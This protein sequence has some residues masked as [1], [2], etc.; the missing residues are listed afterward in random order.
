MFDLFEAVRRRDP[1]ARSTLEILLTYPGVH[2]LAFHRIAHV[3]WTKVRLR[4][5]ARIVSHVGRLLT[6]IEI[7]PGAQI[8]RRVFID[9][10]MGSVL[11]ETAIV[12]DDCLLYH[13]VTLG[14]TGKEKGKRHPTLLEGVVVGAGAAVL[15][16]VTLGRNVKVGAGSVVIQDVPDDCTVVGI[17]ARVVC[18]DARRHADLLDHADLVDPIA[19]KLAALQAEIEAAERVI[20]D[21]LMRADGAALRSGEHGRDEH[22][23]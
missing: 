12:G 14:G 17:P 21:R 6:G 22:D 2:A 23:R 7:H 13:G 5:I 4:L 1:A 3:L 20:R 9:H 11:G 18:R 15:G 8:G 19:E 10:G 16:N